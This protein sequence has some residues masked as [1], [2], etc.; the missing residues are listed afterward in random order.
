MKRWNYGISWP[1]FAIMVLVSHPMQRSVA[2]PI[3]ARTYISARAD[4][5]RSIDSEFTGDAI[6]PIGHTA[7]PPVEILDQNDYY[8]VVN[9][10]PSV[11]C[12]HSPWTGSRHLSGDDAIPMLQ[13]VR[14]QVQRRVNLVHRLDR[15]ASGC[16]LFTYADDTSEATA[17]LSDALH[18][19]STKTYMALVRGEGILNGT[20]LKQLGWFRVERP[21][22]DE[23]GREREAATWFR[24]V[25]GQDNGSGTLDRARASL[26]LARPE[27]GR[28]HQIRKHLN[29]LSHPIL[30]DST[31]GSSQTNREWKEQR[32]LPSARTCLHM[33]RLEIGPTSVCPEGIDVTCPLAPDLLELLRNQLPDVLAAAKPI[34]KEEGITL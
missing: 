22:R 30:G 9:K 3:L 4:V 2:Y 26:V 25:A 11:V 23:H 32:G 10:P 33:S 8:L 29:G 31:H 6:P 16:L 14:T 19:N 15:G 20:D 24:F 34:L 13:R 27:T 12:H 17:I 18:N 1:I 28:W 7:T 21:I 5:H